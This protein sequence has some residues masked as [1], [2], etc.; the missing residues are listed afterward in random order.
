MLI[1]SSLCSI[2]TPAV[3]WLISWERGSVPIRTREIRS[4]KIL[5]IYD[6]IYHISHIYIYIYMIYDIWYKH[7]HLVRWNLLI[8][9]YTYMIFFESCESFF[10]NSQFEVLNSMFWMS[11]SILSSNLLNSQMFLW[12]KVQ[13]G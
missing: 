5:M 6:I 7:L 1:N 8:Y 13:L 3:I 11:V 2:R 4:F 10:W 12:L 9:I